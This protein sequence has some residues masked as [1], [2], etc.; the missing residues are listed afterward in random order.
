MAM[1][2]RSSSRLMPV[3][4]VLTGDPA[5]GPPGAPSPRDGW[6]R[7]PSVPM[8]SISLTVVPPAMPAM[9]SVMEISPLSRRA[10][11]TRRSLLSPAWE[12]VVT[13]TPS[14]SPVKATCAQGAWGPMVQR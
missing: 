13:R 14:G 9:T 5:G 4:G 8:R 2:C 6:V 1:R 10:R 3:R 12:V 11:G 7:I